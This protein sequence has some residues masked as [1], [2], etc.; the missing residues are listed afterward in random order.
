MLVGTMQAVATS[1]VLEALVTPNRCRVSPPPTKLRTSMCTAILVQQT[2]TP[3]KSQRIFQVEVNP[4]KALTW[5]PTT[6]QI[7]QSK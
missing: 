3:L 4:S 5:L 6:Q 2:S 1:A 7:H